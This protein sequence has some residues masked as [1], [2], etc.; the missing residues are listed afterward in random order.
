MQKVILF[1]K[2]VPITDPESV[3]F[4]QRNLCEKLELKGRIII[5]KHGINA[6]LGGELTKLRNYK[7]EMSDH[8]LFKKIMYKWSD[9][10]AENFPKLSIK[11]REEI[12]SFKA[13]DELKVGENGV[14]GG[15]KH[16]KPKALHELI[17]EK[18]DD[19]IFYDGRNAYEAQI[20]QFKNTIVPNVETTKDFIS[21]LES[22]EISNYKDRPIVT[23][24]TGG[25]RCEVL[26]VLMKNRGF[27]EVYQMEGGIIK[28]GEA[29]KNDGLWEGKLYVFDGRMVTEFDEGAKDIAD[30]IHCNG[31]TSRF[32]NCD[33][34]KCNKLIIVCEKCENNETCSKECAKITNRG[35]VLTK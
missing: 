27:E 33:N 21:D 1:Y 19:V 32:I 26:S 10:A 5:S 18:G 22:G 3:M 14:V 30:C 34:K 17:A 12:V 8:S 23:Y 20:G 15:G 13:P 2:F 6:T 24:C 35:R 4:W 9:G 29:F 28:Y 16:L 31:K 11:V 25:I 7:R